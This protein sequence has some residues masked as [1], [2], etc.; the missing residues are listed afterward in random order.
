MHTFFLININL[1]HL[2]ALKSAGVQIVKHH[3][4]IPLTDKVNDIIR[5]V[6]EFNPDVE[7]IFE[8]DGERLAA[9]AV[10][11][12]LSK[13]CRDSGITYKSLHCTRKTTVSRLSNAGMPLDKIRDILGQVNERTTLG[14]IYNPN[15]EQ[16]NLDIMNKAM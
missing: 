7:F 4:F 14:Y 8:R 2:F 9:R 3:R 15:T 6:R 12:W 11:Y 1:I 5:K 16:E 13:Y 10:T